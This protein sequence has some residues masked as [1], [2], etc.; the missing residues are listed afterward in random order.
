MRD[1]SEQEHASAGRQIRSLRAERSALEHQLKR[2]AREMRELRGRGGGGGGESGGDSGADSVG[3]A[4]GRRLVGGESGGD[5][6]VDS[7]GEG[8]REW[9]SLAGSESE[10]GNESASSGATVVGEQDRKGIREGLR[11]GDRRTGSVG[12]LYVSPSGSESEREGGRGRS[13]SPPSLSPSDSLRRTGSLPEKQGG[14]AEGE[15]EEGR[16]GGEQLVK[17]RRDKER[18]IGQVVELKMQ[19]QQQTRR[20]KRWEQE[21]MRLQ[22]EVEEVRWWGGLNRRSEERKGRAGRRFDEEGEIEW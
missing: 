10:S 21:V 3:R 2:L 18:L 8:V 5:S 13:T 16:G 20:M 7:G 15:G 9:Q 6:V 14:S 22:R 4:E 17:L 12:G 1:R 19:L 11:M